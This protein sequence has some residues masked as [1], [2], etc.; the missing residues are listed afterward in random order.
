MSKGGK[1]REAVTQYTHAGLE[2]KSNNNTDQLLSYIQAVE[3][4]KSEYNITV[5]YNCLRP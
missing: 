1:R 3:W 2:V 4:V 5:R